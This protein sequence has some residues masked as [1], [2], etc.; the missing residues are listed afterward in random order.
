LVENNTD[1]G[2]K[3]E[4]KSNVLL[5]LR[6]GVLMCYIPDGQAVLVGGREAKPVV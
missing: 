2:G 6:E 1:Q 4:R 3:S 5:V